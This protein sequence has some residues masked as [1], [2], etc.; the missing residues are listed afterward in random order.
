MKKTISSPGGKKSLSS[1]MSLPQ[2]GKERAA[3]KE[4]DIFIKQD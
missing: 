2:P 3:F 4:E 1:L